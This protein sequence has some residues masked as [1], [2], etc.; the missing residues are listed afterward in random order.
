MKLYN[1]GSSYYTII[2]IPRCLISEYGKKQIFL[3]VQNKVFTLLNS[4]LYM[5]SLMCM[6]K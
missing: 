3:L 6:I 1:R 2:T 5:E 4:N